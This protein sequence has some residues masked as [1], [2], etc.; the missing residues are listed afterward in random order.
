M[1]ET[2]KSSLLRE[3]YRYLR[4][5]SGLE[6]YVF[7]KELS[8]TYAIVAT[9]FGSLDNRFR[10]GAE[11]DFTKVPDGV[12]HFL[13]HKMFEN[14]DGEDTFVKF[15][16]TGADA[17]AYTDFRTTAYLFSCTE[18]FS[19]SLPILLHSVFEP[20][21]TAENVKKEQGIIAQ[22][23]KMGED[24]PDN[25]L[26]YDMLR[27]LYFES[28]LR[29]DIAG[30]VESIA[31]ITPE[32]LYRCHGAFYNPGN[33]IL[34][35][36]GQVD[37][38]E[39]FA[40]V[41]AL[42]PLPAPVPVESYYPPEPSRVCSP[43]SKRKMQVAKPLFCVGVKDT[44]ISPDPIRRMKKRAAFRI[45]SS[46]GFGRASDFYRELYS[47]G[48]IS[49]SFGSWTQ[50]NA[51]FS[52]FSLSGDS[53]D[54]E[55]VFSLI[56]KQAER[57]A[58]EPIAA[59]DFERCRRSH[60]ADFVK[61]FDSTEEIANLLINDFALDGGRIFDYAEVLRTLTPEE[62]GGIASSLF[63]PEAFALSVIEPI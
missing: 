30:T 5:P 8:V 3:E 36:C 20:H 2:V 33:M 27:C 24:D 32:I 37:P 58:T 35:V 1:S 25:V 7:P 17:N 34:C 52:F 31:Q 46:L 57:L 56:R 47:D 14:A 44:D 10:V 28:S 55:K 53:S 62:V 29:T 49:P 40:A 48:L 63:R 11:T 18:N 12:A 4:H 23:I 41:D 39:V 26:I 59:E 51:A 43:R 6:I 60:Y 22:E 16:R 50:H 9:R 19:K 45:L 15:S 38:E 21:F 61:S 42:P 13:E 54:P